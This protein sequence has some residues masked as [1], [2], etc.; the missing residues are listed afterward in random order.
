MQKTDYHDDSF[1]ANNS[2]VLLKSVNRLEEL[3]P[4]T[5]IKTKKHSIAFSALIEVV[6]ACYGQELH[7]NFEEKI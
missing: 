3:F 5:N 2:R 7:S 1:E 6:A 4:V